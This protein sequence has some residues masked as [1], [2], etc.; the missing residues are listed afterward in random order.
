ML[1][2]PHMMS[3][4]RRTV[5]AKRPFRPYTWLYNTTGTA[6]TAASSVA[7]SARYNEPAMALRMPPPLPR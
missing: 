2:M 3:K 7:P 1:G 5:W 6:I 4:V